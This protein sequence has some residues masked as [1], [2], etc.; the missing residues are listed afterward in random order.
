MSAEQLDAASAAEAQQRT[1]AEDA[2]ARAALSLS[3][4]LCSLGCCW[5]S[6]VVRRGQRGAR[7]GRGRFRMR[8]SGLPSFKHEPVPACACA[9]TAQV[10]VLWGVGR[11]Q[12]RLRNGHAFPLC[13]ASVAQAALAALAPEADALRQRI[14][15]AEAAA[16]AAAGDAAG[17][18]SRADAAE[19]AAAQLRELQVLGCPSGS[20]RGGIPD[21]D[22]MSEG[23]LQAGHGLGTQAVR[24][25][26]RATTTCC[27]VCNAGPH[28]SCA[29]GPHDRSHL[30]HASAT[31]SI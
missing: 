4:F 30:V 25:R 29:S 18:R 9:S 19:A 6:G 27:C 28:A 15:A 12:S 13:P 10:L 24:W 16:E 20:Q 3:G 31:S 23:A 8:L 2:E 7:D 26:A 22:W 14:A 11:T 21:V 1:R 17:Q 5:V